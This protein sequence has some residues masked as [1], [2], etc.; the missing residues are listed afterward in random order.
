MSKN[1]SL[2]SRLLPERGLAATASSRGGGG[3][4]GRFPEACACRDAERNLPVHVAL[5]S[6]MPTAQLRA[7]VDKLLMVYPEAAMVRERLGV[8][9]MRVEPEAT[10]R[11]VCGRTTPR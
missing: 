9:G 1:F 8:G 2:Q 3:G 6:K 5:T 7:C 11:R 4:G 10:R